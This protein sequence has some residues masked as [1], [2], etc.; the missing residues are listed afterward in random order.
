MNIYDIEF[1]LTSGVEGRA[2]VKAET[3]QEAKDTLLLGMLNHNIGLDPH[4]QFDILEVDILKEEG[5]RAAI[6]GMSKVDKTDI[7][8]I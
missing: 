1:V 5:A 7:E 6:I 8:V 4:D 2:I 3:A